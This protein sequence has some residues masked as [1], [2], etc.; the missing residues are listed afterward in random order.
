MLK[1]IIKN[2][3]QKPKAVRD[4][5]ALGIAGVFTAMIVM[6][7]AIDMPARYSEIQQNQADDESTSFFNLFSNFKEQ[8]ATAEEATPDENATTSTQVI[9]SEIDGQDVP[10][11]DW[12]LQGVS[13][14]G[15]TS[16]NRATSSVAT[17]TT[18]AAFATSSD[19]VT[20]NETNPRAIRIVTVNKAST[21]STSSTTSQ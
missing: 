5:I 14:V 18:T 21:T 11:E 1:K 8:L 9:K 15:T 2:I 10:V 20:N 16:Q 7:W 17:A 4:N 19:T 3:R 12:A 13:G 6:V